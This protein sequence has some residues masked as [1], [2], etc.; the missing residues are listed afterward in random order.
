MTANIPEIGSATAIGATTFSVDA[1]SIGG[2]NLRG[3]GGRRPRLSVRFTRLVLFNISSQQSMP[4][5]LE[6]RPTERL[7]RISAVISIEIAFS[8]IITTVA[9]LRVRDLP[10]ILRASSS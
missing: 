5:F 4:E 8:C 9:G 3:I 1:T 7:A 6:L 10:C 2:A